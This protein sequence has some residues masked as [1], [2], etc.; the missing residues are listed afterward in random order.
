MKTLRE[1]Q[2]HALHYVCGIDFDELK[3]MSD[4]E[5]NQLFVKHLKNI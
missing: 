2:E 4:S 1:K 3:A 5:V